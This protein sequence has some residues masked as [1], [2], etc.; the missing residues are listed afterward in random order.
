M[1]VYYYC[2]THFRDPFVLRSRIRQKTFRE[3][4]RNLGMSSTRGVMSISAQTLVSFTADF[5]VVTQC[6][7]SIVHCMTTLKTA[8]KETT[9][10]HSTVNNFKWSSFHKQQGTGSCA[11][12][13][14]KNCE[15]CLFVSV[16]NYSSRLLNW[17]PFFLEEERRNSKEKQKLLPVG[18]LY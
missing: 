11:F 1:K 8:A 15:K 9:Q 16:P 7:P 5:R 13:A 17:Y 12:L 10:P 14:C 18:L 4:R 6:S 3:S 2:Y